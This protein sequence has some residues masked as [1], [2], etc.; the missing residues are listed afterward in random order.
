MGWTPGRSL[1]R[2]FVLKEL[3]HF[4][5][6]ASERMNLASGCLSTLMF[7]C[8]VGDNSGWLFLVS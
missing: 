2:G 5:N 6:K 3:L 7:S 4:S 8:L 1:S